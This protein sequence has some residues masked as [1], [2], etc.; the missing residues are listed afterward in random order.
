MS[1][2]GSVHSTQ[3]Y[4]PFP[5]KSGFTNNARQVRSRHKACLPLPCTARSVWVHK[6]YYYFI[7]MDQTLSLWCQTHNNLSSYFSMD[8]KT[9]K[10]NTAPI[11]P[12]LFKIYFGQKFQNWNLIS[13]KLRVNSKIIFPKTIRDS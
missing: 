11:P 13:A 3:F 5:Y 10:N 1:Q 12:W 2:R 8:F 6:F 4:I 7:S 9:S